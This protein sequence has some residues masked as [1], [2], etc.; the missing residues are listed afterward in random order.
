MASFHE[1]SRVY[2]GD[3]FTDWIAFFH[4]EKLQ[5]VL[6]KEVGIENLIDVLEASRDPDCME[7]ISKAAPLLILRRFKDAVARTKIFQGGKPY[8]C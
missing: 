3:S 7:I 8:S 1:S 4:L 6:A 5:N 2:A